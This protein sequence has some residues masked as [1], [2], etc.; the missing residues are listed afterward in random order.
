M[1]DE[2]LLVDVPSIIRSK[3]DGA[4]IATY[5]L[6]PPKV[7]DDPYIIYSSS[8][9]GGGNLDYIG[10][11]G[12]QGDLTIKSVSRDINVARDNL[13]T[14]INHFKSKPSNYDV[15]LRIER[16]LEL[17][18]EFDSTG[19]IYSACVICECIIFN[20]EV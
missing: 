10:S 2:L 4:S 7:F 1:I 20:K 17:P 14:I 12:W 5:Y 9:L 13:K 3:F 15:S 11:T 6:Q 18:I 19:A 16:S 8:D